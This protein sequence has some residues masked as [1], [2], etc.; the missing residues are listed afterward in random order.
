MVKEFEDIIPELENYVSQFQ[1]ILHKEVNDEN[2]EENLH[3]FFVLV[4]I[5]NLDIINSV[6]ILLKKSSLEFSY[7]SIGLC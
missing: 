7:Y 1:D 5:K 6:T 3:F 2:Y 4:I